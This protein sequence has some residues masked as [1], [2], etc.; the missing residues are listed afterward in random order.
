VAYVKTVEKDVHK[1]K[2][3]QTPSIAFGKQSHIRHRNAAKK[4]KQKTKYSGRTRRL[5]QKTRRLITKIKT[6]YS[7]RK[8][9]TF[10]DETRD[11]WQKMDNSFYNTIGHTQMA[12]RSSNKISYVLVAVGVIFLIQSIALIW[13]RGSIQIQW[14]VLLGG[15]SLASF[16][17]LFFTQPQKHIQANVATALGNLAQIQMIYKLYSMQ[18]A[19]LADGKKK[20]HVL[21]RQSKGFKDFVKEYVDMVQKYIEDTE[22]NTATQLKV[23]D[24]NLKVTTQVKET[25]PNENHK[26]KEIQ[27]AL[28]SNISI[29]ADKLNNLSK[30]N[31]NGK[32]SV[33]CE[34]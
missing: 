2:E 16:V 19:A 8:S 27:Q 4:K 30:S 11:L 22:V 31:G 12:Y 26:L 5:K 29:P 18:F 1:S 9:S 14:S 34:N 15:L 23:G 33:D 3:N 10:L 7:G 32:G 17:S 28:D 21:Y 24:N 6:K 13:V 20:N 25:T